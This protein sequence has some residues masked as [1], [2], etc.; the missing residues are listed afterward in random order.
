M[1]SIWR[2]GGAGQGEDCDREISYVV[3]LNHVPGS[4]LYNHGG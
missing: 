4:D 2:F 3:S 1:Q